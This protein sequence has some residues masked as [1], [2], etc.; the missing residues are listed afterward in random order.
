MAKEPSAKPDN[1]EATVSP[2]WTTPVVLGLLVTTFLGGIKVGQD[3]VSSN[4]NACKD[5]KADLE[6]QLA[7]CRSPS[8]STNSAANNLSVRVQIKLGETSMIYKDQLFITVRE[9]QPDP[10]PPQFR[11]STELGATGKDSVLWTATSGQPKTFNG[12][13]IRLT[14]TDS[15]SGLFEVKRATA[16]APPTP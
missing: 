3:I 9:I 13:E 5:Q 12:F 10:A 8:A 1:K 14:A 4:L 16:A 15:D 2:K 6:K 11:I 7:T